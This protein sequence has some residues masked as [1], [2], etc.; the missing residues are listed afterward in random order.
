MTRM[1][2][3]KPILELDE[4]ALER[5]D[6]IAQA[7]TLGPWKVQ[8]DKHPHLLGGQH[9]ERRIRTDWTHGQL[10]APYPV[11]TTSI[12]LPAEKDGKACHMVAI[13]EA[14]AT[15]IASFNPA[16]AQQLLRLA[17]IGLAV[18][19]AATKQGE[20]HGGQTPA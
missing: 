13:N 14:D 20:P 18:E 6:G 7:A 12:G 4:D 10:K 8:E 9:V 1:L 17:R 19:Q 16:V 5:L 11:V 15:F 2:A 3:A